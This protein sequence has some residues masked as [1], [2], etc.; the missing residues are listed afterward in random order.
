MSEFTGVLR[1]VDIGMGAW[2]VER[3]GEA[4]LQLVGAVDPR[5]EGEVVVVTG[6]L[7]PALGYAMQGGE[8]LVL[9][10]LRPR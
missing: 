3:E 5:L 7:R 4:P 8:Q 1:H 10:G 2:V 6:E 9:S